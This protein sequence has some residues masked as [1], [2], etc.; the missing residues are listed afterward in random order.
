MDGYTI[1]NMSLMS[2]NSN[3][4]KL[5]NFLTFTIYNSGHYTHCSNKYINE[6]T[7]ISTA[8]ITRALGSLVSKGYIVCTYD[9]SRG[10][11]TKRYIQ[12]TK[13]GVFTDKD[14]DTY[15]GTA[16]EYPINTT[17]KNK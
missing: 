7:G 6:K 15:V 3:E 10:N 16:E 14:G 13:K 4:Y 2:L 17:T 1:S 9:E 11:D 12:V 5:Y 8:T